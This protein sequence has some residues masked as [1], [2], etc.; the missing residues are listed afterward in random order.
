VQ[1]IADPTAAC[2]FGRC[3]ELAPELSIYNFWAHHDWYVPPGPAETCGGNALFKRE[4]LDWAGGFD[5]SLIAGEEADLCYR[6]RT[7]RGLTIFS[8]L[9]PMIRHDIN[10]KRFSQYWKRSMRTGH[11]YAE[12]GGRH[13][14]LRRWRAACWRNLLYTCVLPGAGALSVALWSWWPLV[15]ACAWIATAMTRNAVRLRRQV[16][17]MGGALLLSSHHYLCK[18]PATLGQCSYWLRSWLHRSPQPLI[19]YR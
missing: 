6:I 13:P 4:V 1:A 11:A 10:M 5:E 8:L 2:V 16:G 19:E 12:V 17:S 18:V 14:G 3:E 9:E 15:F 7:R